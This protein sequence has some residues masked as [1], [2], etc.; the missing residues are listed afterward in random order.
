MLPRLEAEE[1]LAAINDG[2]VAAATVAKHDRRRMVDR[3][4]RATRAGQRV[5]PAKA[6]PAVLA[7]MGIAAVSAPSPGSQKVESDG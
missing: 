4:E 6:N 3:L 7:R 2:A 1:R 5:P